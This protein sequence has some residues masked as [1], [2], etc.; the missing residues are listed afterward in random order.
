[1]L[2]ADHIKEAIRGTTLTL[3]ANVMDKAKAFVE[4]GAKVLRKKAEE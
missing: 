3:D 4:R 2:I 1:M